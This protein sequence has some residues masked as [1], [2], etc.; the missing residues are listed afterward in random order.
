[1]TQVLSSGPPGTKVN[2]AVL[3]DGFTAADQ[4]T[5]DAKVQSLLLDGV[6][7]ND[8]YYEDKQGFN[9]YR[10]NLMSN[11]SGVSQRKYDN[12][13]LLSTT[14]YDTALGIIFNGSWSHC[15]LEWGANS[16]TLINNALNTWV[17]DHQAGA[18]HPQRPELRRMRRRRLRNGT[19]G[20]GLAG[21]RTRVRPRIRRFR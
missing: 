18:D 11:H 14:L 17:P 20:C 4:A 5:Y 8:Y 3:G 16:S 6:F 15:W 1:M 9:I 7:G 12:G 21:D 13:T 19:D 10:V 2:I